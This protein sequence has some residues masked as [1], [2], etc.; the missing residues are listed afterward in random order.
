MKRKWMVYASWAAALVTGL[1]VGIVL[2]VQPGTNKTTGIA[3][4]LSG[5]ADKS[6]IAMSKSYGLVLT[7]TYLCG[8]RDEEHKPVSLD[9]LPDVMVDYKGWEIVSADAS[10]LIL[11]K[12]EH[13]LSPAC[14]ENGHFGINE[15]GM[16][17]LFHGL[18]KEQEVVQAFYRINTAKME[19][20]LSKEEV[21]NLKRG[22]RI[23]DLAEYNSVLSTYGEFQLS[24]E[25]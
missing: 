17:T 3:Q 14:K 16:L 25:E 21:D 13:D 12:R 2:M 15:D 23:R 4:L 11:L 19:A 7:R 20:S 5:Q 9:R 24:E 22:I 1:I 8:V 10:K 18:P 6:A